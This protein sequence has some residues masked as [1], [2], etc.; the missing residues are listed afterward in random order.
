L[1]GHRETWTAVSAKNLY[2]VLGVAED[3]DADGIRS[4]YRK[5]AIKFHPDKNP[6]DKAAEERFKELTQAY[7]VLSD[8]KKR[9]AYD[10][11]LHGGFGGDVGDLSDLFGDFG[12]F[13]IEDIL[14][15][16]G[17]L[18]GGFGVPFHARHV[19]RRGHDVQADLRVDFRTA[20]RGGKVDV[21]MRMPS[22]GRAPDEVK[23]VAITVPEGIEDGAPMRLKGMGEPSR[24]GGPPGDLILRIRVADHPVFRR[25][26]NTLHVDLPTPAPTAVLG[27]KSTVRTLDGEATVTIPAGTA[28]GTRLRLKGLGIRGGDLIARVEIVVPA[29]P[30]PQERNLYEQLR[31]LAD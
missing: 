31:D 10:N 24:S 30:T 26:G 7:E 23:T 29:D 6:G 2:E 14:G 25:E 5:L 15:R 17:D 28:A 1:I 20:A 16:H 13:S 4:A 3:A 11:R 9:Q 8:A 12:S 18:F 21:R 19:V 22:T 27:G